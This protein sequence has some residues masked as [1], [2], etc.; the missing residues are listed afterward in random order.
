M[1]HNPQ[2]LKAL[3]LSVFPSGS[4]PLPC[5]WF[6]GPSSTASAVRLPLTFSSQTLHFSSLENLWGVF[7]LMPSLLN[8]ENLQG[9]VWWLLQCPP[10][11]FGVTDYS[12]HWV[13]KHPASFSSWSLNIKFHE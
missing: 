9:V 8:I 5:L 1:A 11:E 7:I 13:P 6:T 2:V 3:S 12:R 4:F 10:R